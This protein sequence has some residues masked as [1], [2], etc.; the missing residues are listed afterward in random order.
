[1]NTNDPLSPFLP[2]CAINMR[3]LHPRGGRG[4][5]SIDQ[6]THV[7]TSGH[8]SDCGFNEYRYLFIIVEAVNNRRL[9][10]REL[11]QDIQQLKNNILMI[12]DDG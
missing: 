9:S 5:S 4:S 8:W 1:M 12:V 6:H 3:E 10:G 11:G 2:A 7:R